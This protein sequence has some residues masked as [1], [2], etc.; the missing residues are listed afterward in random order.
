MSSFGFNLN[1]DENFTELTGLQV[2]YSESSF[3][4]GFNIKFHN[5]SNVYK[6]PKEFYSENRVSKK[7]KKKQ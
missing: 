1:F 5:T 2:Q 3:T 6:T 4:T 7:I